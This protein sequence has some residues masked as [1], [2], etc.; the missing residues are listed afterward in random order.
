MF[1]LGKP[2][3]N[4]PYNTMG[5]AP[6]PKKLQQGGIRP[7]SPEDNAR[8]DAISR[9]AIKNMKSGEWAPVNPADFR[10]TVDY[11]KWCDRVGN[12]GVWDASLPT[13]G[14]SKPNLY[15]EVKRLRGQ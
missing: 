4:D 15:D 12:G 8:Y 13:G 14:I 3:I 1:G 10:S 5:T 6:A 9:K 2:R 11:L 7:R